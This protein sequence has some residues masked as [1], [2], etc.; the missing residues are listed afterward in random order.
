MAKVKWGG[1]EL[2]SSIDDYDPD[3]DQQYTD[4]TGPR[5]PKGLYR[6]RIGRVQKSE[7]TNGFPQMVV[8]MELDPDRAEH[9]QYAGYH[10]RDYI[11]V[12]EDGSTAF[13][14]APLLRALGVTGKQFVTMTVVD[15]N[16]YITKM[17]PKLIPGSLVHGFIRPSKRNPEYDYIKY[18][19]PR[20]DDDSNDA[21][22]ADGDDDDN[23]APF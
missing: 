5:P 23:E 6:F 19:P 12:K 21:D 1:Q 11:I 8:D 9:K 17:G 10:I 2:A 20:A 14:Y 16:G 18:M 3:N 7:S 22:D 13:R 4:Y 15:E